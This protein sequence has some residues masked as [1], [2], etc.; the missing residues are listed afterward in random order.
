MI[1]ISAKSFL[2]CK[3]VVNNEE[4]GTQVL[5][6]TNNRHQKTTIDKNLRIKSPRLQKSL[7]DKETKSIKKLQKNAINILVLGLAG[8]GKCAVIQSV[9]SIHGLIDKDESDLIFC[10][11]QLLICRSMDSILK[12]LDFYSIGFDY[13][14]TKMESARQH[15]NASFEVDKNY[16]GSSLEDFWSCISTLWIDENVKCMAKTRLLLKV[17]IISNLTKFKVNK[18]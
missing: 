5:S 17:C 1:P 12:K 6:I 7:I 3:S 9:R 11:I 16:E 14:T 18:N 8:S 2:C 15:F 4:N 10:S 13:F